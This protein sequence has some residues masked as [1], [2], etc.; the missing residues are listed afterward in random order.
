[1]KLMCSA[2]PEQLSTDRLKSTGRATRKP[3][4]I[5]RSAQFPVPRIPDCRVIPTPDPRN[6][7]VV[8]TPVQP[9]RRGSGEG[10]GEES[11]GEESGQHGHGERDGGTR[12]GTEPLTGL[13]ARVCC[14]SPEVDLGVAPIAQ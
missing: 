9:E 5:P 7:C 6:F 14:R 11:G 12:P 4:R 8:G 2:A 3:R 10:E 1:M 13:V